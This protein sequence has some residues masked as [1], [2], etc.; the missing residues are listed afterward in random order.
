VHNCY[1]SSDEDILSQGRSFWER[2]Q[3]ERNSLGKGKRPRDAWFGLSLCLFM[4]NHHRDTLPM[5]IKPV[6]CATAYSSD[7]DH[8]F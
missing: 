1:N 7:P 4:P 3:Q 8:K 5:G 2:H 6:I